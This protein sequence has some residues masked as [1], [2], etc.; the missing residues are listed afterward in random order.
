MKK[1]SSRRRTKMV[2]RSKKNPRRTIKRK[3]I[4]KSGRRPTR[5]YSRIQR[6]GIISRWEANKLYTDAMAKK[7]S[8]YL[9]SR[10]ILDISTMLR[11][12]AQTGHVDANYELGKIY[13]EESQREKER[14]NHV[15]EI[16]KINS[17]IKKYAIA[18]IQGH[19]DA[20]SALERL[21]QRE[22]TAASVPGIDTYY[23]INRYI[24][25]ALAVVAL[26]KAAEKW[27]TESSKEEALNEE[28]VMQKLTDFVAENPKSET[29]KNALNKVDKFKKALD[30]SP[31]AASALAPAPVDDDDDDD[32]GAGA[33]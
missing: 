26:S 32:A 2:R 28:Q 22:Y 21:K 15:M 5:R 25:I 10:D 9:K 24:N 6:G 1:K 14:N 29:A 23:T 11:S 12:A 3:N 31:N 8:S 17:A 4:R 30:A 27:H 7:T 13:E 16:Q 18:A 19:P 33:D 20:I